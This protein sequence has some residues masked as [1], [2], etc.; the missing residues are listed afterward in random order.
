[1]VTYHLALSKKVFNYIIKERYQLSK[2]NYENY[3]FSKVIRKILD[4][5]VNWYMINPLDVIYDKKQL[6]H[7]HI[8]LSREHFNKIYF[9]ALKES[10]NRNEYIKPATILNSLIIAKMNGNFKTC[11]DKEVKHLFD[12]FKGKPLKD[13]VE[14]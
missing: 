3:S 4:Y 6:E 11:K 1:M 2:K 5:T 13:E 14:R 9:I 7:K 12:I 8:S 10:I